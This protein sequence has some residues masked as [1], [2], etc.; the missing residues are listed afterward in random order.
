MAI[1]YVFALTLLSSSLALAQSTGSNKPSSIRDGNYSKARAQ[2]QNDGPDSGAKNQAPLKAR[3]VIQAR[4]N[5]AQVFMKSL[6]FGTKDIGTN[7]QNDKHGTQQYCRIP[8]GSL[9]ELAGPITEEDDGHYLVR[10]AHPEKF[11]CKRKVGFIFKE[12]V[13]TKLHLT[14]PN[15]GYKNPIEKLMSFVG[16]IRATKNTKVRANSAGNPEQIT[17]KCDVKAGTEFT[18]SAPIS[19]SAGSFALIQLRQPL[20]CPALKKQLY[21][22]WVY[23]PDWKIDVP[24]PTFDAEAARSLAEAA[25]AQNGGGSTGGMCWNGVANSIDRWKNSVVS[26][27]SEAAPSA[28]LFGVWALANPVSLCKLL[29]MKLSTNRK[30][31]LAPEGAIIW[32]RAG[33]CGFSS[34]DGHIEVKVGPK[35]SGSKT[36]YVS[37]GPLDTDTFCPEASAIFVPI[38]KTYDCNSL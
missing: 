2:H 19:A 31:A 23:K 33:H 24:Q 11:N 8:P 32:H 26:Y 36:Y 6:L 15:R 37:D 9:I 28:H 20:S 21:S 22:F 5:V 35:I 27:P 30:L 16:S 17:Q 12:H 13:Y 14:Q 18:A 7:P 34:S 3:Y 29:N 4:T 1:R 38:S 10:L 25:W